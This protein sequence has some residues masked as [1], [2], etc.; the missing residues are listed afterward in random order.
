MQEEREGGRRPVSSQI[1]ASSQETPAHHCT[2][3]DA[4]TLLMDKP[5]KSQ[6]GICADILPVVKRRCQELL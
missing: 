6:F 3:E 4:R 1:P 5:P 2:G